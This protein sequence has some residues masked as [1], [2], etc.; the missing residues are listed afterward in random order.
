MTNAGCP[1]SGFTIQTEACR[2]YMLGTLSSEVNQ[3]MLA[4]LRRL[5][6]LQGSSW[7]RLR[8]PCWSPYAPA[9]SSPCPA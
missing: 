5:E 1:S 9:Q 4:A 2:E 7:V 8:I 3:E 6:E